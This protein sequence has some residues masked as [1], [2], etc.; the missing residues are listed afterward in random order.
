MDDLRLV[1][2]RGNERFEII[3]GHGEGS[4]V[5]RSVDGLSTHDYLAPTIEGAKRTAN[6]E[7]RLSESA[8]N[9]P[10]DGEFPLWM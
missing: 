5:C 8:W 9:A 2:E 6:V 1:A 4:Y 3:E 7:W 10:Q